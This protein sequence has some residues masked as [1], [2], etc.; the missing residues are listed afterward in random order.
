MAGIDLSIT[1]PTL[2]PLERILAGLVERTGDI[3]PLMERF[4]TVLETSTIER[5]STERG[6]DGQKWLPSFRVRATSVG[7][8]GPVQPSGKTLTQSGRLKLS[9]RPVAS[10]DRVEIGT[11]TIYARIHQ[12]GG[13]IV[14]KSAPA[15]TFSLPGIGLI[16]ASRVVI[17]ARPFLGISTDDRE[18]LEAQTVDYVA[19]VAPEIER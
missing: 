7:D 17:P 8:A 19:E 6:P 2:A 11:N 14:P 5:F 13:T 4:G 9:I 12:L 1:A 3:E 10:R 18:E 16:H 15:L